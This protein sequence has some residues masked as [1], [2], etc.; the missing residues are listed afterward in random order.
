MPKKQKKPG[1]GDRLRD[2]LTQL[3]R[4]LILSIA[5][6]H[7]VLQLHRPTATLAVSLAWGRIGMAISLAYFGLL[8]T[9]L[10]RLQPH[11]IIDHKTLCI[12]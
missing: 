8:V 10:Q 2:L 7:R 11:I 12:R 4:L 9:L 5:P 6:V 3:D 1:I